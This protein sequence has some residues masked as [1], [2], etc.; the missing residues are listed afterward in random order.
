M[1]GSGID[2][3]RDGDGT[4]KQNPSN[5][6]WRVDPNTPIEQLSRDYAIVSRVRDP[7]TEQPAVILAGIGPW[8]SLAAGEFVT[9]H[10][11]LK[12]LARGAPANWRDKNLQ[13]EVPGATA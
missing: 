11:Y 1:P 4:N 8:G 12:K 6:T 2:R 10:E 3:R 7:Q 9:N 13:V 5:E